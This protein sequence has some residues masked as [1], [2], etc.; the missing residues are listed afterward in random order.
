[1]HEFQEAALL[2]VVV[3]HVWDINSILDENGMLGSILKSLF[4]Y[5]GNPSLM[6][7]ISYAGYFAAIWIATSAKKAEPKE[8]TNKK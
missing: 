4:G 2:P 1:M 6:E 8:A 3:E 5:N 7:I